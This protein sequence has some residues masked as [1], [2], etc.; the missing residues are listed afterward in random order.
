MGVLILPLDW[1]SCDLI[2]G[3]GRLGLFSFR[4]WCATL[5]ALGGLV[6][7]ED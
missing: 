2:R 6:A 1:D 7:G 4:Y 3:W 5:V